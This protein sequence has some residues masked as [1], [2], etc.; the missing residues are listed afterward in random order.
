MKRVSTTMFLVMVI[1]VLATTASAQTTSLRANVPFKFAVGDKFLDKGEYSVYVMNTR[2]LQLV[3]STGKSAMSL[4]QAISPKD[5]NVR[6]VL[7][8]WRYGDTY[9]LSK[10]VRADG[11]AWELPKSQSEIEIAR[12]YRGNPEIETAAIK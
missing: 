12:N 1:L 8:F 4:S 5:S 11:A 7:V 9:F 3:S 10:V 2:L 6:S